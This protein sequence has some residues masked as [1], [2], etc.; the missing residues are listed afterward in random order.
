MCILSL[1]DI[2]EL[3]TT[4]DAI[5]KAFPVVVTEFGKRNVAYI[6]I[7]SHWRL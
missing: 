5:G 4:L 6:E 3:Y 7:A 1:G 2:Y